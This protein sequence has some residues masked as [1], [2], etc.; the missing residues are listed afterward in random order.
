MKFRGLA[1][2]VAI[3]FIPTF[4]CLLIEEC[5]DSNTF[6]HWLFKVWVVTVVQYED[7]AQ[8]PTVIVLSFSSWEEC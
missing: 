8:E 6:M 4:C 2:L 3:S 7:R 1:A 5:K